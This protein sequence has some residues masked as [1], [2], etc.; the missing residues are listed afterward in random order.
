VVLE[1]F[2]FWGLY[3]LIVAGT[4]GLNFGYSWAIEKARIYKP[5]LDFQQ[6]QT[7]AVF[8]K[9]SADAIAFAVFYLFVY[10]VIIAPI[11]EEF[12]F[13]QW[14]FGGLYPTFGFW[15]AAVLSS[16]IWALLHVQ[17]YSQPWIF[18]VGLVFAYVYITY[19]LFWSIMLH[20]INNLVAVTL[21]LY[22]E[23]HRI[24]HKETIVF[25]RR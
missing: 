21:G 13:R 23:L 22:A 24:S 11:V 9:A 14:F 25:M 17:W 1:D 18:C 5:E 12:V 19:G 6:K 7:R 10:G 16:A 4:L 2:F 15:A 20:L 8:E 3:A